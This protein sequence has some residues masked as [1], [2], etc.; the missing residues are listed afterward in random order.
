MSTVIRTVCQECHSECGVLVEVED[1]RVKSIKG[2]PDHPNSRGYICVKGTNY[3]AFAGHPDRLRHP[4]RRAG[5]KGEGKWERV[6]WDEALD[7]IAA[8][9]T[10]IRETNGAKSL[11]TFHGTAPRQALFFARLLASAI[12]TPNV[13]NTDLHIC[14]APSMVGE[15]ATIG[16]SVCQ[17]QG[18]DYLSSKCVLV[19]GANPTISHPGRGRDLVDAVEK[20]GAK[21]I[22]VDPRRTSLAAMAD[23][24]LPIR[25]GTDVALVLAMIHTIIT[26]Q[27]YDSE[28]VARYCHGFDE[29]AAHIRT[30]TPE[31]AAPLTWLTADKIREAAR[32]YATTKPAALHRRIGIEQNINSTQTVRA[33]AILAAITGNIGVQGGNLLAGSLPGFVTTGGI[34]NFCKL[35]PEVNA[36]R[37]GGAEY[38]LISGADPLFLFVHPAVFTEAMLTGEPYPL[39][40]LLLAGGNP[41]VNMQNTRRAWD[42]FKNLECFVVLDF[43][44]TPTAELADYVLPATTWLERDDCCDEVYLSCVAA[45]QKAIEPPPECRDDVQ[46]AIDLAKRIP[47]AD[48]KYLPWRSMAEF[49]EFRVRGTGLSFAELKQRG[50][51]EVDRKFPQYEQGRFRTP[52]GKVELFSTIFEK[53]GYDPLPSYS[54]LQEGPVSTPDLMKEY[55]YILITGA[56]A[57]QFYHSSGRQ[58]RALRTQSPDPLLDIH[59]EVA[60]QQNVSNGDWVWIE[61]PR[62]KGERVRL[63]VRI[64]QDLDPRVVSA[65]HGW[66]FPEVDTPDH[67]CFESNINVILSDDRP[68]EPIC[69][70]VPLR[71]TICRLEKAEPPSRGKLGGPFRARTDG[72]SDELAK[73]AEPSRP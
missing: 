34:I 68:R 69:G 55:P 50:Y 58:I 43:F 38:P 40:A 52:T 61:T 48:P 59:P 30:C 11:G 13:L 27:L 67:G 12:G 14:Y 10:R 17:E 66:W 60:R 19:I 47:W 36:D 31:W 37:L 49:N 5:A 3:A 16:Q 44:M 18:P 41:V 33:T 65:Q 70:S 29:L 21:L 35:P 23:I 32:L 53:H 42:A 62:V 63:K 7:D 4:L 54:E 73:A 1:G 39:K 22:V 46:I 45:R 26:E 2:D 20:N 56:R 24:W 25:P 28:F 64:T 57:L 15:F 6:S 71:G 9:L 51:I 8:R 72:T